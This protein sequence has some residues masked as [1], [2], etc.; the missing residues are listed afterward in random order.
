M[1][2]RS[3]SG[4]ARAE[5]VPYLAL[6]AGPGETARALRAIDWAATPLGEPGDWPEGLRTGLSIGLGSAVPMA[7]LWG[8]ELRQIHN[9]ACLPLLGPARAAG[10]LLRPAA[11]CWSPVWAALGPLAERVMRDGAAGRICGQVLRVPSLADQGLD[12]ERVYTICCAPLPGREGRTGGV[13]CTFHDTTGAPPYTEAGPLAPRPRSAPADP[14][15]VMRDERVLLVV[16]DSEMRDYLERILGEH[17][18]TRSVT[19]GREAIDFIRTERFGMVLA[20]SDAPQSDGVDLVGE[21]RADPATEPLP[22][23]LLSARPGEE[24]AGGLRTGADDYLIKP[25][26]GAELVARV[27][28][29]L[30]M[31]RLRRT[32]EIR[33]SPGEEGFRALADAAPALVWAADAAR[34]CEFVNRAWCEYTGRA[35]E[36][37]VGHG[38]MDGVHPGD[39]P[40][41][42]G[43]T[44]DEYARRGPFDL[45]Y[46]LRRADG[47]YGWLAVRGVPRVDRDGRFAG[48]VGAC[49]DITRRKRHQERLGVLAEITTGLDATDALSDRLTR[50]GAILTTRFA[51]QCTVEVSGPDSRTW[52]LM[53]ARADAGEPEVR[54]PAETLE[55]WLEAGAQPCP[56]P[57]APGSC[58]DTPN[59][60]VSPITVH[61]RVLGALTLVG[62][63]GRAPYDGEDRMIAAELARRLALHLDYARLLHVERLA[64]RTVESAAARSAR[65]QEITASLSRALTVEQVASAVAA[66][67]KAVLDADAVV[68]MPT[69]GRSLT[70]VAV[71]A[72]GDE[73]WAAELAHAADHPLAR[74]MC[75]RTPRWTAGGAAGLASLPLAV[76]TQVVGGL[77]VRLAEPREFTAEEQ[78]ELTAIAG[79]GAYA[80][81]RAD[82]FDTE[83][84]MA[85]TLQRSLLPDR[86]PSVPGLTTWAKYLTASAEVTIG[87]D[88]Y[89]LVPLEDDRVAVVIGDV[90]GNGVT[91][92]SIMGQM[93]S[94][95]S[96]YLLEGHDPATALAKTAR[97]AERLGPELMT[98]VCCG[99]LHLSSGRFDYANAGHPP[100]LVRFP[101]GRVRALRSAVAP[102]LGVGGPDDYGLFT[103]TLPPGSVLVMYTDGLVERRGEPIDLGMRRLSARLS[104]APSSLDG[105]GERL[106]SL[107]GPPG[108]DDTAVLLIRT[109]GSPLDLELEVPAARGDLGD[110]RHRLSR[111][112]RVAHLSRLEEYEF[113]LACSEAVANAAEHGH[114][115]GDGAISVSGQISA[116]LVTIKVRDG[117]G[118]RDPRPSD[119]GRGL[120]LMRAVMDS[121]SIDQT[122]EGTTVRMR[123][124]LRGKEPA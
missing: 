37:E 83:H 39:L 98:T 38:W 22:V 110:L 108:S 99:V 92:A 85:A 104:T 23:V 105:L 8:R 58:P 62:G 79:L 45:E 54:V 124:R 16:D 111:W 35:A 90:S 47:S 60:I 1:P 26:S 80:L 18:T 89:D 17:W 31:G 84:R 78:E 56:T 10:A 123:R 11:E 77:A 15:A 120:A 14:P 2:A 93:R 116:S 61:G 103:E 63:D 48:F 82:R 121:V 6:F 107:V 36:Q 102:P 55:R 115:F 9:D 53:H 34:R 44:H 91:A 96:A 67:A 73:A 13:L 97:V 43:T 3:V 30:I 33:L 122:G 76:G 66:H 19:C 24:A 42:S 49:V 112:L 113:L 86:L 68:V 106:I 109:S 50:A 75:D 119:R 57:G 4:R 94:T 12:G 28:A 74:A 65:L 5:S 59:T 100:P 117:G 88:W 101:D 114:R 87:G 27:G 29:H 20:D 40:L 52:R 70:T 51:E 25:F 69:A 41:I 46:R 95:L 7:V 21:I 71:A 81:Q 72:A 32:R 64:R 118:W